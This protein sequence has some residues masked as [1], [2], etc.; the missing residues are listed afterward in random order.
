M[1]EWFSHED[2]KSMMSNYKSLLQVPGLTDEESSFV[3]TVENVRAL[4]SNLACSV[5]TYMHTD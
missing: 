2:R 5:H 3:T 1:K 4:F